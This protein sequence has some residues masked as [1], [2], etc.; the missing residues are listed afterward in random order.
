MF[1]DKTG[2]VICDKTEFYFYYFIKSLRPH[3]W[4]GALYGFTKLYIKTTELL[5][6]QIKVSQL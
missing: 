5:T 6:I 2:S 1:S 4:N 3:S